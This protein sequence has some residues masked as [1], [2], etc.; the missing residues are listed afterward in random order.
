MSL[1]S[2]KINV[3]ISVKEE[4]KAKIQHLVRIFYG[5][6]SS[7][8][9]CRPTITLLE[10]KNNINPE[11]DPDYD[12]ILD[13]ILKSNKDDKCEC[14]VGD[15]N[16]HNG[17]IPGCKV[18][19][20]SY[21]IICKDSAISACS[22]QTL[23]DYIERSIDLSREKGNAFDVLYLGKWMDKCDK[24]T[25]V[26][27]IGEGGVKLVD[28]IS[29]NG[30]LS[31]MFTP[32]GKEKFMKTFNPSTNPIMRATTKSPKTFGH[33]LN[34]LISNKKGNKEVFKAT[35]FTPNVI[36]FNVLDRVNDKE[37]IKTIECQEVPSTKNN[38]TKLA[39]G[40]KVPSMPMSK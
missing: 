24:Y 28:T 16:C 18:H 2:Y 8:R 5:G 36:N 7:G 37:L 11:Y 25:N 35:T 20:E 12:F 1:P 33:H 40:E 39:V 23:Y 13:S 15:P 9:I 3:F 31:M 19:E 38:I 14:N 27:T 26:R 29:P 34:A 21:T 30:I 10:K 17:I 32:S 22:A 6:S 4:D